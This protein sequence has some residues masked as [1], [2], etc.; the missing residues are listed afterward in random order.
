MTYEEELPESWM[1]KLEPV[2]VTELNDEME[3]EVILSVFRAHDVR[4]YP[5]GKESRYAIHYG[6]VT[7]T[8]HLGHIRIMVHPEDVASATEL[9]EAGEEAEEEDLLADAELFEDVE[10]APEEPFGNTGAYEDPTYSN[11]PLAAP[12]PTRRV[13]VIVFVAVV[14]AAALVLIRSA[15]A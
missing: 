12:P 7:P 3:A 9:L 5:A 6:T 11:A 2:C 8:P 15:L 14:V 10:E 13:L 1:A 4:A